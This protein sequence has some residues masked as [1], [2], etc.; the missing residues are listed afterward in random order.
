MKKKTSLGLLI[1]TISIILLNFNDTTVVRANPYEIY[2]IEISPQQLVFGLNMS[3]RIQFQ[4]FTNVTT[5][6]LY[7]YKITEGMICLCD[8]V[9]VKMVNISNLIECA[10]ALRFEGIKTIDFPVDMQIGY[11]IQI[12]YNNG[13]IISIPDSKNFMGFKT[14]EPIN[15]EVM[16]DAGKVQK[17]TDTIN[18]GRFMILGSAVFILMMIFKKRKISVKYD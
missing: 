5:T 1:L 8:Y 3:V 16:F 11:R 10:T 6:K 13:S 12:F 14:I 9:Y 7:L 2:N 4:C 17:N 15:N 18:Y